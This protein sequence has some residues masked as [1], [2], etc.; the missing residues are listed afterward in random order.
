MAYEKSLSAAENR[1]KPNHNLFY[2]DKW[3]VHATRILWTKTLQA[4]TTMYRMMTQR[5]RKRNA[6]GSTWEYDQRWKSRI[7]KAMEKEHHCQI[8]WEKDWIPLCIKTYSSNAEGSIANDAY[9][10]AKRLLCRKIYQWTWLQHGPAQQAMD[11]RRS[12]F[13][14][15]TLDVKFHGNDYSDRPFPILVRFSMLPMEYYTTSRL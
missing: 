5:K 7:Q 15:P 11:D 10:S 4:K 12:L 13:A 8:D 6:P 9:R 14:C 2:K 3:W 1:Q